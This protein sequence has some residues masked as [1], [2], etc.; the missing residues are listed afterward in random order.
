[1]IAA[2][3]YAL[4]PTSPPLPIG[5]DLN[6]ET[7]ESVPMHVFQ[8]LGEHGQVLFTFPTA[9]EG[10]QYDAEEYAALA[11][12]VVSRPRGETDATT[13]CTRRYRSKHPLLNDGTFEFFRLISQTLTDWQYASQ[14]FSQVSSQS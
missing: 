9:S 3:I 14:V 12:A 11:R 1:M 5:L 2:N 6:I 10:T 7:D 8:I 13:S 4:Y